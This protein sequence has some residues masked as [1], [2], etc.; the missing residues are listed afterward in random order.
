MPPKTES[1]SRNWFGQ[2]PGLTI[3]FL[4]Q[5]WEQFSYYGMYTLLVLY[6]T[7][8]LHID[9]KSSSLIYGIYTAAIY[10]LPIIGGWL[11][12]RFLGHRRAVVLG[13][14]IMASGHFMMI[15]PALLYPALT[16]IACG[17]GLFIPS[18]AGQ[19]S[20]L[21]RLGDP[22]VVPAYNIYY[23]GTNL[24]GV[25]SFVCGILGASLGWHW[26]FGAAGFGML[27]GLGI[28]L[29]GSRHLPA[30]IDRASSAGEEE[31][32]GHLTRS[33]GLLLL[34]I[35]LIVILFRV[36][37]GQS[38]NTLLQWAF[39]AIDRR[40]FGGWVIPAPLFANLNPLIVLMLGPVLAWWWTREA[41]AG[42][43]SSTMMKMSIGSGLVGLAFTI[44]AGVAWGATDEGQGLSWLWLVVIFVVLTVGELF[45]L[46]VGLSLFGR[47]APRRLAATM[48]AAWFFA[49]AGGNLLAGAFGMLWSEVEPGLFFGMIGGL[50]MLTGLLLLTRDRPVRDM[51]ARAQGVGR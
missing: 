43:G 23:V 49:G 44:A 51:E 45:I 46:P 38:G 24:G 14:L 4:T 10:G 3:L 36:A 25:V 29:A 17:T 11:A 21:Y 16:A 26:G 41:D 15:F 32:R 28:Y 33:D 22:R 39:A 35:I 50:A 1:L 2:P 27:I 12:D 31:G 40:A 8:E 37:Y 20:S 48:I 13:G 42:R 9:Q 18:V 47:I 34:Q 30:R 6:M 7:T 19:V 5:M